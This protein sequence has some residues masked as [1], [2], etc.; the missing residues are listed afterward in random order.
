MQL[1]KSSLANNILLSI[2]AT[3]Y[4]VD[5]KTK[6][7]M[8]L[9]QVDG[10]DRMKDLHEIISIVNLKLPKLFDGLSDTNREKIAN[11]LQIKCYA[12]EEIVFLQ[13]DLPDAYYSVVRGA[14]S[15]YVL[16]PS[17]VAANK[18]AYIGHTREKYGKLLTQLPPGSES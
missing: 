2:M 7:L 9:T 10:N 12:R 1:E 17:I 18:A 13:N 16:R 3:T 4:I 5:E 11:A 8:E 15:L 14:V 6:R